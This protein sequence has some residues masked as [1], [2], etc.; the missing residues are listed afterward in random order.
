MGEFSLG[1]GTGFF[2]VSCEEIAVVNGEAKG[3]KLD[4]GWLLWGNSSEVDVCIL[5]K[6]ELPVKVAVVGASTW[7]VGADMTFEPVL[8]AGKRSLDLGT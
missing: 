8:G 4:D 1:S 5:G 7:R 3:F 6:L 2:G